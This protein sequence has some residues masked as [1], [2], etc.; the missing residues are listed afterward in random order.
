MIMKKNLIRVF[1]NEKN[2]I[3]ISPYASLYSLKYEINK[4]IYDNIS[5]DN[6][7]IHFKG[8]SIIDNNK[9]LISYGIDNDS[10][11]VAN[12]KT[13]GGF[14]TSNVLMI[15]IYILLVPIY[16]I[17]LASGVMPL[18][19]NIFSFIFDNT[20]I[21]L[22]KYFGKNL[23]KGGIFF[24]YSIKFI[25]W[26]VTTFSTFIFI[27]TTASYVIF[28]FYYL[29]RG[30]RYCESGLKAKH[31]GKITAI[32]Y[33]LIYGSYNIYDFLLNKEESFIEYLPDILIVKGTIDSSIRVTK[34]AW[35]IS[36]FAPLYAIPFIG[37]PFMI[38]HEYLEEGLGLLYES[39]DI[40]SQYNCDDINTANLL[41]S[42]FDTLYQT[43]EKYNVK[44]DNGKI[45]NKDKKKNQKS[46]KNKANKI[47]SKKIEGLAKKEIAGVLIEPI[48]NYK[49]GFL[50]KLLKRGF[51]D[52]AL[53]NE[54]KDKN[55]NLTENQL[56]NK[57]DSLEG[58]EF[59]N[60][61]IKGMI[62]RWWAGS[63][64]SLFC[65]IL[66]ALRDITNILWNVGTENDILNMIKT[67]Q[68]AGIISIIVFIIDTLLNF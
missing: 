11:L 15:I 10:N 7:I 18:F 64:A 28:P 50:I 32:W 22:L 20:V 49:L 68:V 43:L 47:N 38:I 16:F 34:E 26:V 57:L 42:F 58:T 33:M 23:E 17:F 67:G 12:V 31:V 46:F 27:W 37:E 6:I 48:K 13:N 1:V 24:R 61:T 4:K 14:D 59:D 2:I 54:Y 19:A 21:E 40:I 53:K 63:V 51:C 45:S 65:Q 29:I 39:L 56:E 41:C 44:N 36:K 3:E 35:D 25:M 30:K 8:K 66:E 52:K 62:N 5:L 55:K 60:T 9:S